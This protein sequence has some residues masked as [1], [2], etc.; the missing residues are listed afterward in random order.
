MLRKDMNTVLEALIRAALAEDLGT[1]PCDVTSEAIVS[2]DLHTTAVMRARKPG[3][4][5]GL[6]VAEAVFRTV[7][8]S[9]KITSIV[10]N[11]DKVA[12]NTD[13]LKIKG[14]ALSI[15]KAER[16]ALNFICHLSGIATLTNRYIVAISGTKAEILD[17]RKTTPGV[18]MLQKQAVLA[19]GGK[20]HRLG[21]H[22]AI[23]IK[24]NHISVAKSVKVALDKAKA[25]LPG[26]RIEIEVDRLEQ[27]Q[28]VLEHGGADV[29]L[30]DNMDV[31][32]LKKAV[33]LAKG[34]V[35]LEASGGVTLE[36]VRAIAETGVDRISIGALTHSAP[37]LDIGL[38]IE[39]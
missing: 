31:E 10:N 8:P 25:T 4:I 27:L 1:P 3:V 37:A 22:D 34:R 33:A 5:A 15:L 7:D 26:M 13:L 29:V 28:E 9:L 24:D 23:L 16:V 14:S 36:T 6:D 2:P 35:L 17:T 18:R 19:G 20:N 11:R 30:L 39:L 32:T 12:N 21:L 38:D